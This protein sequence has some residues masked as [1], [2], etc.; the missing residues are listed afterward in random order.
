VLLSQDAARFPLVP[1]W[2]T[3][4]GVKGSRPLVGTWDNKDLVYCFAAVNV[5]PG[6]LT[7]RLLEPP[8][9]SKAQPG[10]SKHQRLQAAFAAHLGDIARA[11]PGSQYPTVLITIDNAPWH[12]GAVVD[13]VLTT[14]PHL[15]LYRLPSYS[16]QLNVSER[17]W[18]VLR[19]RATHNRLFASMAVL[20]TT[21]RNHISD[22]QTM[23]QKGLSLIESPRK[24]KKEA[25]VAAA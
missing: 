15:Q 18:R 9:R 1:T 6:Q 5:V 13:H 12:R 2:R 14:H 17:F 23:R 7:T 8:A 4:L 22:F 10:Q 21:L 25:K 19:R 16:P 20:R 11:Y 24:T 3:T